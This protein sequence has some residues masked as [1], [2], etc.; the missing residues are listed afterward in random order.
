[1]SEADGQDHWDCLTVRHNAAV[2]FLPAVRL[3]FFGSC[4]RT[5]A[6]CNNGRLA[7]AQVLPTL[8]VLFVLVVII[9]LRAAWKPL[10]APK[11]TAE[12]LLRQAKAAAGKD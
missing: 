10:P 8:G 6:A 11:V 1:M 4:Y 2:I 12:E 7:A 9:I 3:G 5:A